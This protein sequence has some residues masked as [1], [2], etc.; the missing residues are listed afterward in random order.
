MSVRGEFRWPSVGR[1]AVRPW[2]D[3]V[4]AYGEFRVAAVRCGQP[5]RHLRPRIADAKPAPTRS[6]CDNASPLRWFPHHRR[7]TTTP[8]PG[9]PFGA[10]A[11]STVRSRRALLVARRSWTAGVQSP[12]SW[13]HSSYPSYINDGPL[14]PTNTVSGAS[15]QCHLGRYP[16]IRTC[17]SVTPTGVFWLFGNQRGVALATASTWY[18]N[19]PNGAPLPALYVY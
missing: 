14:G 12:W 10:R 15:G 1:S 18:L 11:S 13:C 9:P 17:P 16:H 5:L 2:G 8:W 4:A 7:P 3:S 6:T 19:G